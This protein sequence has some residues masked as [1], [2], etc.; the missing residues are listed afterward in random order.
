VNDGLGRSLVTCEIQLRTLLQDSW[1]ELTHEDTYKPGSKVPALVTTLAR[2][3]ADLLATLDEIAEDLRGEL[4]AGD[5]VETVEVADGEPE[6]RAEDTAET[7]SLDAA[8]RTHLERRVMSL[9]RPVDLATLAWE[10]QREFGQEIAV[11]WLGYGTFKALL[12]AFVPGANITSTPPTYVIP[13]DYRFTG[14]IGVTTPSPHARPIPAVISFLKSVDRSFPIFE[15]NQWLRTFKLISSASEAFLEGAVFDL[16]LLNELTRIARDRSQ[17]EGTPLARTPID[18][19]A[20]GVWYGGRLH[21]GMAT[22]EVGEAFLASILSRV[23]EAVTVSDES[24]KELREW[25]GLQ[26]KG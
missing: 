7:G 23:S 22:E 12:K 5:G 20:K 1:G 9:T 10:M 13:D 26:A 14:D 16:R 6:I 11:G 25:L 24:V 21:A 2:R 3:M 18:Y 19:V 8:A 15:T 17:R 4:D